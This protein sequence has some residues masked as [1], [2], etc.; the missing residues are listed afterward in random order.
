ME[1]VNGTRYHLLLGKTDWQR[2]QSEGPA[3]WEF[4]RDRQGI[5]LQAEVFTLPTPRDATP[6]D[7]VLRR[8]SDRDAYGHTYWIDTTGTQIHARWAAARGAEVLFPPAAASCPPAEPV[9]FRPA[10]L[11]GAPMAE[12]LSG[13]AVLPEGYLVVGSPTT[14]SLLVFDLYALDGGYVRLPLPEGATPFDLAALADGGLLVL[15]RDHRT[16]W[17]LSRHLRPVPRPAS[18]PGL[19]PLFQPQTGVPRRVATAATPTPIALE[20]ATV[21]PVA[22]A[23]L[24]DGSFWILDQPATGA[25]V[26]WHYRADGSEP[27]S[28]TLLTANLV[29]PGAD[30]LDLAFIR[31]YDLA[32]RPSPPAA[33]PALDT[34]FT[35]N[36]LG[37]Q[38]FALRVTSLAPLTLRLERDYYPLRHFSPVSLIA[39]GDSGKIYYQQQGSAG[40]QWLPLT[41]LPRRRYETE[42]SLTLPV[43]DGR[44][45]NCLW[46][47]L[48]VDACLPPET[49]LQVETRAADQEAD[50]A[51]QPWQRQP[52]FYRRPT[53]E[54]PYSSLWSPAELTDPHTATWELLF[55]AMQG[56]YLQLRLTLVGNGRS[57]PLVRAL[58][59]HYPRF[60]Y[61]REYLPRV[62]QQ[63]AASLS[64]LDRFL[65]N[66][67][68]IFTLV[69]GL[70]AQVQT[71][72]DVRTVPT[73]ALDW[74]ASWVGLALDPAWSP[75][76]RRLLIAQ[77]PYFFQRRGTPV[78]LLQAILL[79]LYP[80]F[81]PRIFR[82]DAAE[83]CPTVRIVEQFLTRTVG[84]V[85]A[86]D[87]TD[88]SSPASGPAQAA[89]RFI[90]LVPTTL[91]AT[92][93]SLVERIVTLE[94]PAHTAFTLKPY[95]ALFRVGEVRLGLDTV[96]GQGGQF[97][98]FRL[99]QSAL[100]EAALGEAFPYTLTNRTVIAR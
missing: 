76:Q 27:Q 98:A 32:Y 52:L 6:L 63:D 75:Y 18:S 16:V 58:R 11:P 70:M 7:P 81:G 65:A 62:Y 82:D 42:A 36:V 89:H 9:V 53:A 30:D 48:C 90:V 96:L 56:R 87:P 64:F 74:L 54:V 80:D 4:D 33:T 61:L 69:E 2:C 26:V 93:Q 25:S 60:S 22:I 37:N 51:S 10:A 29:E 99:G 23:P 20:A 8:D 59:A 47:R 73:E 78:G 24:P 49:A 46:H 57:T 5:Q 100:A 19:V 3:K 43:L 72:M 88:S 15:D 40:P 55:Q 31:G 13:L 12:P 91:T 77:A 92:T 83:L 28:L 35:V 17:R 86:G 34:L 44:E 71:L 66:P 94:K 97:D 84:G 41:A 50:L 85:A 38:A 21:N 45:P 39:V 67:E 79:T 95:W 68:G 14:G 1:D